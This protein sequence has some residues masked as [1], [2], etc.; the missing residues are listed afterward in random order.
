MTTQANRRHQ[1]A[2]H[3]GGPAR[4]PGSARARAAAQRKRQAARRARLRLAGWLAAAAAAAG[5]II[6]TALS[7]GSGPGSAQSS[8]VRAA[9]GFTL[10]ST[11]G[12]TVSLA[13]YRGR[14]VVLYFNEGTGCDA[15]FYQMTEFQNHAADLACAGITIVPIVMNPVGQVRP[16]LAAFG[17]RTPYLIDATG[18]VSRPY[19]MF[20]KGMHPGLPGHGFV[21]IDARG[22]QRWHGEY[23]SMYLSAAGLIAQVKA[24]L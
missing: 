19:G 13:G 5:L 6:A 21:L 7:A 4:Q 20:G 15:C 10:A 18:S 1:R 14:D 2:R 11:S 17:I 3:P 16:H 8:A 9:P 23:P 12:Q 22:I 24:H